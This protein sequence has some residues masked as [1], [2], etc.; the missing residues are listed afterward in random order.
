[1]WLFFR[2]PLGRFAPFVL[3]LIVGWKRNQ[4]EK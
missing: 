3:R 1:M 4:K 2:E